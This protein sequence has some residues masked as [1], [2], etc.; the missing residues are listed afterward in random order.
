MVF[1]LPRPFS[2]TVQYFSQD[3]QWSF[4]TNQIH[5]IFLSFSEHS[6][7]AS[8]FPYASIYSERPAEVEC[9]NLPNFS[10]SSR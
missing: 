7:R 1:S 9:D 8:F 2:V 3:I 5:V 10:D 4:P 6:V